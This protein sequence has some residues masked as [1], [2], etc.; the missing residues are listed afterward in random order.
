MF[1]T[2]YNQFLFEQLVSLPLWYDVRIFRSPGILQ[3]HEALLLQVVRN[4][5][6]G[7]P[8]SYPLAEEDWLAN[9]EGPRRSIVTVPHL[10]FLHREIFVFERRP[11]AHVKVE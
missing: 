11:D 10:Q 3:E 5:T 2:I 1:F 4:I 6:P 7:G 9:D 8:T